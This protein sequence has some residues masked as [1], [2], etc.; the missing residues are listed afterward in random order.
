MFP[1][2]FCEVQVEKIIN[3]NPNDLWAAVALFRM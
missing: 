3:I 2:F 1:G